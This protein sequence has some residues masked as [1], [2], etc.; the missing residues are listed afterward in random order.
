MDFREV[1]TVHLQKD[2][3]QIKHTRH[4]SAMNFVVNV[5]PMRSA[6]RSLS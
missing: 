1:T 2:I 3:S 6:K 5:E 4:R